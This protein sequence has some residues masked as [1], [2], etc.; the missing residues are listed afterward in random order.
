MCNLYLIFS[1]IIH[2]FVIKPSKATVKVVILARLHF[3]DLPFPLF[4]SCPLCHSDIFYLPTCNEVSMLF[5]VL[6]NKCV[7]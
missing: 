7:K 3:G 1:E 6:G 4:E 2:T 5:R